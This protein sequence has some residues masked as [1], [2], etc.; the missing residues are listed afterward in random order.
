ML[1]HVAEA[2]REEREMAG[3]TGA[4]EERPPK[5]GCRRHGAFLAAGRRVDPYYQLF[6]SS[7]ALGAPLRGVG[8]EGNSKGTR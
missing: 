8:Q 3:I 7:L 5:A 6:P 4:E 2:G 1:V